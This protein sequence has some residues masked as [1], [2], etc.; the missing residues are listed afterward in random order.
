VTLLPPA[1]HDENRDLAGAAGMQPG[2]AE[3]EWQ[4]LV[5]IA[6]RCPLVDRTWQADIGCVVCTCNQWVFGELAPLLRKVMPKTWTV[7]VV[8]GRPESVPRG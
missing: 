1:P 2:S 3:P 4:L 7:A 5:E 6:E 8:A